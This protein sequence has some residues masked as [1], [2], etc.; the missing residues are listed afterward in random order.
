MNSVS[1]G[2][3]VNGHT[4]SEILLIVNF[5][6]KSVVI[7][8]ISRTRVYGQITS[9]TIDIQY[10]STALFLVW[11]PLC[12]IFLD[13]CSLWL[14]K[15][16]GLPCFDI[17]TLLPCF[18]QPNIQYRLLIYWLDLLKKARNAWINQTNIGWYPTA[19]APIPTSVTECWLKT[20]WFWNV[21]RIYI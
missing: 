20:D 5:T 2:L 10:T 6:S 1:D 4:M 11:Y 13:R 21:K 9:V 15:S 8:N 7:Q 18:F 16:S 14:S 17:L 19:L 3:P 12:V